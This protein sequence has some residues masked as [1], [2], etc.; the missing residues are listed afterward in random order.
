MGAHLRD[1][2]KAFGGKSVGYTPQSVGDGY[3]NYT[4][5]T[6]CGT[7]HSCVAEIQKFE[8][9]T[10]CKGKTKTGLFRTKCS[11]CK[12]SVMRGWENVGS[13][14]VPLHH[15]PVRRRLM[16]TSTSRIIRDLRRW[17]HQH[18]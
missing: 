16:S 6:D 3:D 11:K 13:T 12:D 10:K 15:H 9:C 1:R 2:R 4:R 8:K 18:L 14:T 7:P 5:V 17:K